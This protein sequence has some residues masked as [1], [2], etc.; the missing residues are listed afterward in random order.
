MARAYIES[1]YAC[2]MPVGERG[3]IR[4]K[5]SDTSHLFWL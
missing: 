2:R 3:C 4:K 1:R 5:K